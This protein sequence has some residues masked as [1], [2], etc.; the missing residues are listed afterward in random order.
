MNSFYKVL[1]IGGSSA[2]VRKESKSRTR[3]MALFVSVCTFSSL[4]FT[5]K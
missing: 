4:E 3:K 5:K 1:H 2:G